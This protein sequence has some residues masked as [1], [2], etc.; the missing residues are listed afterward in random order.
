MKSLITAFPIGILIRIR[1]WFFGH[2]H[3]TKVKHVISQK[4]FWN[5]FLYISHNKPLYCPFTQKINIKP[6]GFS[7]YLHSEQNERWEIKESLTDWEGSFFFFLF[8][9]ASCGAWPCV[10]L[11]SKHISV[12]GVRRHRYVALLSL[13]E[14]PH[15]AAAAPLSPPQRWIDGTTGPCRT[16]LLCRGALLLS[17]RRRTTIEKRAHFHCM[18]CWFRA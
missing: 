9:V 4:G 8:M 10:L 6:N 2:L 11:S 13:T 14:P 18:T 15:C 3:C 1:E 17:P 5:E 7:S 12:A 16:L